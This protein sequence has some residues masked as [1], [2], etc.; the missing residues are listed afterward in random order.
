[1]KSGN[2]PLHLV[3]ATL[4]LACGAASLAAQQPAVQQPDPTSTPAATIPTPAT[5]V[6][7]PATTID[8][9]AATVPTNSQVP[10]PALM[11]RD[12]KVLESF[13]ASANEEYTIGAGDDISLRFPGHADMNSKMTVGPDGRISVDPAPAIRVVDLTRDGAAEAIKKALSPYFNDLSVTVSI[14]KYSSNQVKVLGY[15]ERPGPQLLEGQPTLLDAILKAGVITPKS[16]SSSGVQVNTG[17]SVP[18]LCTVYR[19]NSMVLQVHLRDLLMSNDPHA[20]L[21]L[22]RND[23]VVVPEPEELFVSVLGQVTKPGTHP[24][25]RQSTLTSILAEAGCCSENGGFNPKI[26]IIQPSTQKDFQISYKDVMTLSGQQEYKLHSGDVIIV[27]W[28]KFSKFS[29]VVQK[30]GSAATMVSIAAFL[31]AG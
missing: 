26:H 7:T 30:V 3:C 4:A 25:T 17:S 8:T 19:G 2:S 13:A 31:G 22:R 29:S 27:P 21:P 14:D 18:E 28:S 15:V 23:I 12:D 6:P 5:T 11:M 20:N 9:P 1:M 24:L 16:T 10:G